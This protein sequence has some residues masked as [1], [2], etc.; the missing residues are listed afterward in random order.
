MKQIIFIGC[1]TALIGCQDP[2][3]IKVQNRLPRTI[4]RNVEWG[5]VPL[6]SHL[7]SGEASTK[8][9]IFNDGYYDLDLPESHPLKFYM[10]VNGDKVYLQTK[11]SFELGEEEDLFIE[12]NSATQ[13]INPLLESQ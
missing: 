2:S 12:I 7:I 13:V 5:G 1:F 10:E 8:T 6:S 4:M 11:E 3:S 9:K